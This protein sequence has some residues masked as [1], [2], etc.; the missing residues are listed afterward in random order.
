MATISFQHTWA[1][2]HT[3]TEIHKQTTTYLHYHQNIRT[4]LRLQSLPCSLLSLLLLLCMI[5]WNDFDAKP[6]RRHARVAHLQRLVILLLYKCYKRFMNRFIDRI[7]D[8]TLYEWITQNPICLININIFAYRSFDL[9]R[10]ATLE[11]MIYDYLTT[12][13]F[14]WARRCFVIDLVSIQPLHLLPSSIEP[15]FRVS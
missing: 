9:F 14:F 7:H 6:W 10:S 13:K 2:W 4:L 5:W 12:T 15:R 1:T 3:L 8:T 11:N